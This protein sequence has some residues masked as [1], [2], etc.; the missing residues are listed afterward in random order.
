MSTTIRLVEEGRDDLLHITKFLW[1]RSSIQVED[2]G[3]SARILRFGLVPRFMVDEYICKFTLAIPKFTPI[4]NHNISAY[5]ESDMKT[6]V[7]VIRTIV[8]FAK[9]EGVDVQANNHQT[10][11]GRTTSTTVIF[12]LLELRRS[13][14]A[15]LHERE[16]PVYSPK[17]SCNL[18]TP[19]NNLDKRL[20]RDYSDP[21]NPLMPWTPRR[22]DWY[23][24]TD[25]SWE[26]L[27]SRR[28][29]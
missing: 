12:P 25:I 18:Y 16:R 11:F 23:S 13:S 29:Q 22:K 20:S 17:P 3:A 7:S 9:R 5:S 28:T 27:K 10:S 26:I 2:L 21:N 6:V 19:G 14:L 8:T 24:I 1:K 15:G 4:R